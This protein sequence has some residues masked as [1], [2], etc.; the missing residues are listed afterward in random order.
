MKNQQYNFLVSTHSHRIQDLPPK[1]RPRERLER[2]G[3]ASLTEAELLAILL[4]TGVRGASAVQ[5]GTQLLQRFG[6]LSGLANADVSEIASHK[7]VGHAKAVQIKAAFE[8]AL[9]THRAMLDSIPLD[10]PEKIVQYVR[11]EM[12]HLDVEHLRVLHLNT[13]L[14]LIASDEVSVGTLSEAV[15]HPREIFRRVILRKAY[16][17][18]LVHNHPSGDPAPSQADI[19]V[20]KRICAGAELLQL[21]FY[22]HI[23]I[24]RPGPQHPQG[25][26]SFKSAGLM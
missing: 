26:F 2:L 25:Y 12:A 7:G 24:G 22:D 15:A 11:D 21:H 20:T 19:Q 14:R 8:L 18:V 4:R 5:L 16:G 6:G 9:R 17:F 1:E 10:S 13:R 3:A 23:I